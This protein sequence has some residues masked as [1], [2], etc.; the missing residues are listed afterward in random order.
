MHKR[1]LGNFLNVLNLKVTFAFIYN[2]IILL[3]FAF[4]LH[5]EEY[6]NDLTHYQNA[7]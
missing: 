4:E 7:N 6:I 5:K 1:F 3:L 2:K